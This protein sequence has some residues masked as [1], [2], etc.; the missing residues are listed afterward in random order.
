MEL[1]TF[2]LLQLFT[3]LNV[4]RMAKHKLS[5]AFVRNITKQGLHGDDEGL[6]LQATHALYGGLSKSWI[7]RFTRGGKERKCG[8]GSL[9]KMGL[10]EARA[11][12]GHEESTPEADVTLTSHPRMSVHVLRAPMRSPAGRSNA[13][14]DPTERSQA[15]LHHQEPV[16]PSRR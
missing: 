6:Y 1:S 8:L 3:A 10:A 14:P 2:L 12:A 7:L 13:T 15:G 4:P 16:S 9:S 11:E 5:A